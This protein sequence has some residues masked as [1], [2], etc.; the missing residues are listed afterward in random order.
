MDDTVMSK[1]K[2]RRLE[3]QLDI[4]GEELVDESQET[5][6]DEV[7]KVAREDIEVIDIPGG[8]MVRINKRMWVPWAQ[9]GPGMFKRYLERIFLDLGIIPEVNTKVS[10]TKEGTLIFRIKKDKESNIIK[11]GSKD[12]LNVT[13]KNQ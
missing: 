10:Y 11:P 9:K 13:N 7:D 3:T 2:L 1:S 4:T 12:W 6:T 8:E 5:V